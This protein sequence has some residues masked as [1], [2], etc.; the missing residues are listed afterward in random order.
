MTKLQGLSKTI[1][2]TT[3]LHSLDKLFLL[4]II[5]FLLVLER[6]KAKQKKGH[7]SA[8]DARLLCSASS[9][10]GLSNFLLKANSF[11]T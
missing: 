1:I 4:S 5:I 8:H 11:V 9:H 2:L 10:S 3:P 6:G 7:T